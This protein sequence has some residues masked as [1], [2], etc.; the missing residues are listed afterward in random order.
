MKEGRQL[1]AVVNAPRHLLPVDVYHVAYTPRNYP[2]MTILLDD[3]SYGRFLDGVV[4]AAV[5]VL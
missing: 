2:G 3:A 1:Q 4:F 5:D